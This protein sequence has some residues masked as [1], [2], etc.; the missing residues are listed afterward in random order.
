[1]EKDIEKIEK[2]IELLADKER[3]LNNEINT[4]FKKEKLLT[5]KIKTIENSTYSIK[6]SIPSSDL[7]SIN[8]NQ[9]FD[10]EISS[11]EANIKNSEQLKKDKKDVI[12]NFMEQV[13]NI[14]DEYQVYINNI[15]NIN[16][17]F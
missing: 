9:K 14:L 5:D 2:N 15:N 1:M 8:L 7:S 13:N 6:K 12:K 16:N 10:T 3:K 17:E 11:L 4:F